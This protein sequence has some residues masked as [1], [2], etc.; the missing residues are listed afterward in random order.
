MLEVAPLCH[1]FEV[2]PACIP[3]QTQLT[4]SGIG[5]WLNSPV[6]LGQWIVPL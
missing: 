4:R 1:L 5:G 3:S 2:T 6:Y